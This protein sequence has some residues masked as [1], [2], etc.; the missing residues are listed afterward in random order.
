[1]KKSCLA[2]L[3]CAAM[4][5]SACSPAETPAQTH[6]PAPTAAPSEA[7]AETPAPVETPAASEEPSGTPG[8]EQPYPGYDKIEELEDTMQARAEEYAPKVT[9]LSNGVQVQRTPTEYFA[10]VYHNP[11]STLYYNNYYLNADNR[12]CSACHADMNETLKAMDYDHVDLSNSFGIQSTVTQCLDCHSYS[13]GYLTEFYGFGSLIHGIHDKDSGF[14][15]DCWSC[16]AATND[17]Q[18]MRLWDEAKHELLRGIVPVENVQGEFSFDQDMTIPAENVFYFNWLCY[19]QDYVRYAAEL[20][21]VEADPSIF[22]SWPISVSGAVEN[23][24]TMTLGELIAEAPVVETTMLM[25]CTINPTGGPLLAN[26]KIKGVPLSWLLE[27]A[28]LKKTATTLLPTA[29]DGFT[30]PVHLSHLEESEAYLVYEID[31]KRLTPVHGYP[32]QLWVGGGSAAECI[33]QLSNIIVE[34]GP[35]EDYYMYLGWETE[36]GGYANKPNVGVFYTQEGQII[37]VGEPYT[38]EGYADAYD[39]KITAL[40]FSMD[41]GATWTRFDTTG[42]TRDKW[43]YWKFAFTPQDLGAYVLRVRA[44][45]EDGRVTEEPVEIMVNAQYQ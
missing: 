23:E 15:G 3:L 37:P 26:C 12:G 7:P 17:G 1:M 18:G 31:G 16:H 11:A 9:T 13:P 25:H 39:Q 33:K 42:A 2:L 28:G 22:D 44:L 21:G 5:L 19:D 36:E 41:G 27:K 24:F 40:E 10:G 43:V 34:E 29:I 14:G 45:S 30:I 35:E 32:V 4:L 8:E 6:T 20:A 38:F